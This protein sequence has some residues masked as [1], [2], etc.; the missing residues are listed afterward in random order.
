MAIVDITPSALRVLVAVAE[1]G[2]F[3]AAAEQ[4]GYTQ[5]AVSK[6]VHTLERTV[7]TTVFRREPR[8]IAITAAGRI[9]LKRAR[10]VIDELEAARS[11]LA[12]ATQS[13]AGKVSIGVF[14]TAATTLL[15]R[16]I[17]SLKQQHPAIDLDIQIASSPTQLRRLGTGRLDVAVLATGAG[18]PD[19]DLAELRTEPLPVGP[20][21]LA[22]PDGHEFPA[23][24]RVPVGALAAQRWIAGQGAPGDPQ[25]GPW[26]TLVDPTIAFTIRDWPARLGFV[27]AGLGIT[28][29]PWLASAAVPA[30]VRTVQV[31]D[32][33]W[34]GRHALVATTAHRSEAVAAAVDAV[35]REAA[36]VYADS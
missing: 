20:L 9:L 3:T 31:D 27:A 1:T 33:G 6:Q 23:A 25:F 28:T 13:P 30:G 14:P 17:R 18:L 32:P 24:Q 12:G 15:P 29:I 16:V 35:L 21:L 2:S 26:P 8:G 10:T 19:Y 5:S 4:L 7:G 22:V 34:A 11:E 36:R